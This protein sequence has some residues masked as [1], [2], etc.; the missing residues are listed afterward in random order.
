MLARDRSDESLEGNERAM[1]RWSHGGF[2][3]QHYGALFR[4]VETLLYQRRHEEARAAYLSK[5]DTMTGSFILRWETL[6]VMALLLRGRVALAAWLANP[7]AELRAEIGQYAQRLHRKGT[8]WCRPMAA[9]LSS[10]IDAREGRGRDAGLTLERAADDLERLSLHGYAAAA[11]HLSGC[12][13]GGSHG[14]A[15]KTAAL[16]YAAAQRIQRPAAF[17][18]M[19]VPGSDG[20]NSDSG[21]RE[22]S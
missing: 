7:S 21:P 20:L 6:L 8:A 13:Q 3:L 4:Q 22:N 16:E 18:H 17:F 5:W 9:V 2:Q 12:L 15:L 11:R 1:A 19:L 14:Q 10:S